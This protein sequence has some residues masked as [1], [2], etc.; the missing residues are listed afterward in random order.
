MISCAAT[1][2]LPKV[3]DVYINLK[4]D[5][6]LPLVEARF[7]SVQGAQIFRCEGAKALHGDFQ[8]RFFS[9]S[10][11]KS[12]RVHTEILRELAKKLS[13]KTKVAFV[14]G[15]ILRPVLQYR[16]K[17]QGGSKE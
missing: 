13:T 9:N 11:T 14:Q 3:L 1:E 7:D 4:K 8:T 10:V 2:V 17:D 15:F 16:I 12:T 5:R 6:G